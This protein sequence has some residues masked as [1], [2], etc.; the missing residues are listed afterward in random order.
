M[1]QALQTAG[2]QAP[3]APGPQEGAPQSPVFEAGAAMLQA[4]QQDPSETNAAALTAIMVKAQQLLQG[5]QTQGQPP[6][7]GPPQAPPM[8]GPM[9]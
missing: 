9:Q 1:N 7:G 4:F 3:P 2:Q 6:Q 8:G 5:T